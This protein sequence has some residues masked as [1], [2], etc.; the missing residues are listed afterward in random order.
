MTAPPWISGLPP[1]PLSDQERAQLPETHQ[2]FPLRLPCVFPLAGFACFAVLVAI[3]HI[4]NRKDIASLLAEPL[5]QRMLFVLVAL[6]LGLLLC[7][8]GWSFGIRRDYRPHAPRT[9]PPTLD[10]WQIREE[11]GESSY[12]VYLVAYEFTAPQAN[13]V[14][15]VFRLKERTDPKTYGRVGDGYPAL[16]TFLRD[17]PTRATLNLID[18]P[19]LYG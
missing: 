11:F 1:A 5:V 19:L 10:R 6:T 16:I 12:D 15:R 7:G 18:A 9:H 14:P 3:F 13:G 2:P 4:S 17:N 8:L